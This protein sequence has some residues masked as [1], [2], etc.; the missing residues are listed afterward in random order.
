MRC[1][2]IK[3]LGC[4]PALGKHYYVLEAENGLVE[5]EEARDFFPV[6]TE[7]DLPD[8]AW[9]WDSQEFELR[10]DSCGHEYMIR[11]IPGHIV[12]CPVC[13]QEEKIPWQQ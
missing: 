7:F 6:G 4:S 2:I 10:C 8:D 13:G 5:K 1:R 9:S 11:T 3:H 12:S